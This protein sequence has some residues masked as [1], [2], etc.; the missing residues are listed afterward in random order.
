MALTTT[1]TNNKLIEFTKQVNR[2]WVRDNLFAPY[3]GTDITAI[4]RKRMELTSGGEQMNI[5]LV[6]RLQAQAVGSG[7]LAGNEE[8]IDNYGMRVWI[9][10]ARNA[11]KT[12][13]AEKQ[14]DSAAIF[15]V[16]RPL[17]SDWIKE[18]NRDEIIQALYALPTE[19]A[20]AGL[21]SAAGQRVNGILFDAAT[22]AQRNT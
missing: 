21:G 10:W 13:K 2:E 19:S 20:P 17:L 12:N 3:M 22:A 15:G 16:A 5:P 14:K 11:V 8:S 4:I 9:D 7:A 18:L 1:Q 6:A